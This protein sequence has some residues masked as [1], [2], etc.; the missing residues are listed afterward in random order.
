M[1][2]MFAAA[3]MSSSSVCAFLLLRG[4]G[5]PGVPNFPGMPGSGNTMQQASTEQECKIKCGGPEGCQVGYRDHAAGTVPAQHADT[6]AWCSGVPNATVTTTSKDKFGG[7][8]CCP[9]GDA[10]VG[11]TPFTTATEQE[12]KDLRAQKDAAKAAGK[13]F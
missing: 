1:E 9:I 6:W 11:G 13:K 3:M 12:A 8:A 4:G 10:F 2:M 7:T 5:I